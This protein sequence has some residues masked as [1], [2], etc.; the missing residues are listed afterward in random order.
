MDIFNEG[1]FLNLRYTLDEYCSSRKNSVVKQF[2]D[3]LTKGSGSTK[4]I[5]LNSFE[6]LRYIG[7]ML[8]FIHQTTA[9]EYEYLR[10]MFR[11]MGSDFGLL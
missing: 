1:N 7:D 10:S 5:E 8:A 4:P 11:K 6:P 2:I 9:S 3:A